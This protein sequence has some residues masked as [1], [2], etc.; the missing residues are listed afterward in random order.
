VQWRWTSKRGRQELGGA[1]NKP[2]RFSR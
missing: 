2:L 1:Y